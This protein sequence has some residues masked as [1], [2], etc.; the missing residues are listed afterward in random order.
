MKLSVRAGKPAGCSPR[1]RIWV[2]TLRI[3]GEMTMRKIFA[4]IALIIFIATSGFAA[5]KK[6]Q[7][8]PLEDIK[9]GMKAVGR[10]IFQGGQ[11]EEFG[12]EIL[13]V[14]QGLTSSPKRSVII[15]RLTGPLTDRS[16][17]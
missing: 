4:A 17:V 5:D 13:G 10:T 14:L 8:F 1:S 3:I 12:V 7:F 2:R 16:G 9:P 15:M 6:D 11:T